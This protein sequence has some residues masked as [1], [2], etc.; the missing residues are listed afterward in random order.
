MMGDSSSPQAVDSRTC[1]LLMNLNWSWADCSL[2]IANT[3]YLSRW[4]LFLMHRP[5]SH[6]L[7]RLP[8]PFLSI[9]LISL[10]SY[11]ISPFGREEIITIF[12]PNH[13]LMSQAEWEML[14]YVLKLLFEIS[15]YTLYSPTNSFLL[16]IFCGAGPM[17]QQLSAHI[18]L[19]Q[20]GVHQFGSRVRT[21]HRLAHH[22][23]VVIPH[24]K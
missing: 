23:V 13:G 2:R 22:A 16:N 18:P 7:L 20:P 14:L 10:W 8:S 17:G 9:I 11:F 5:L 21:W 6:T 19:L 3:F 12:C 4:L 24:I 1:F 15:I